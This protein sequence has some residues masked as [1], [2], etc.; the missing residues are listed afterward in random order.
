MSDF[1]NMQA[2]MSGA[3]ETQHQQ[4]AD[5]ANLD[6]TDPENEMKMKYDMDN[7]STLM[8]TQLGIEDAL[9]SLRKAIAQSLG[10][11]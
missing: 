8:Q 9:Q 1:S 10:Q 5:D 2:N 7:Y 4:I 3:I 6:M 11:A